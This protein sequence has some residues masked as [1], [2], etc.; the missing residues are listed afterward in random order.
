MELHF[1][2]VLIRI[3]SVDSYSGSTLRLET[4]KYIMWPRKPYFC[5]VKITFALDSINIRNINKYLV[6]R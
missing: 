3:S 5:R 2:A 6:T 1:E 4:I